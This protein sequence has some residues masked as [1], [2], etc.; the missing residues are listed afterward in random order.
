MTYSNDSDIFSEQFLKVDPKHVSASVEE[1]GYFCFPGAVSESF[2]D[3]M[4][5]QLAP[6]RPAANHNDVAPV[7]FNEQYFFPHAM[8]SSA[9]YFKYITSQF[10]RSICKAKFG[11]RF[12]LKCHRYYETS[13]GH[14]MEWHADNVTNRGV[15]TDV[16]GLIFILYVNDVYDGEFQLVCDSFKDRKQGIWSY[17]YTNKHIEET[18]SSKIKSFTMPAGSIIVYDTYG[19]H[20]A[21]PIASKSF[22]RKSIF[23][24][25]DASDDNAEAILLNPAFIQQRDGDLLDY[26]GFGKQHDF[27]ANPPTSLKTVP[28]PAL[29]VFQVDMLRAMISRVGYGITKNL[30]SHDVRMRFSSNRRKYIET[31]RLRHPNLYKFLKRTI[32]KLI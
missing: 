8:A 24:Q 17:N 14:S 2:L 10:L 6:H 28:M 29:L 12:R 18:Y 15:V 16:D 21:K 9:N 23:F 3:E 11:P 26:L 7:W 1:F 30:L 25:V 32:G 13:C 27:P 5:R 31:L 22:S 20:R 19:I 4:K